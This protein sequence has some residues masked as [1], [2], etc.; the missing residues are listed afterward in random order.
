MGRHTHYHR[1]ANFLV[2]QRCPVTPAEV[3]A[4]TGSTVSIVYRHLSA[5]RDNEMAHISGWKLICKGMGKWAQLWKYGPGK[6]APRPVGKT[7]KPPVVEVVAKPP[8]NADVI[9]P[10]IPKVAKRRI[11]RI[12]SIPEGAHKTIFAGGVNPWLPP[13]T[14]PEMHLINKPNSIFEYTHENFVLVDYN[15]HPAIKAPVAV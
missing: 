4:G 7:V 12:L 5:M 15:P 9:R 3:V 14:A 11:G 10:C 8:T 13:Q 6:D 1:I 2:Q